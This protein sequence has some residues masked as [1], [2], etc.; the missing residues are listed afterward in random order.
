[1]ANDIQNFN[2]RVIYAGLARM[3]ADRSVIKSAFAYWHKNFQADRLNIVDVVTEL[4]AYLGL[5]SLEKKTLMVA[6][7]AASN[8]LFDE[9]TPVPGVILSADA[10]STVSDP[11][12]DADAERSKI[13]VRTPHN[14]VTTFYLKLFAQNIRK[15]DPSEFANFRNLIS[16]SGLDDLNENLNKEVRKWASSGLA[17]IELPAQTSEEDCIQI[18]H[19]LYI[20]ATE[21]VGPMEA[22]DA[23]HN[24][25]QA[26][27]NLIRENLCDPRKSK[28]II[29]FNR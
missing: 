18:A 28:L 12:Q 4:V 10:Q 2:N 6:L 21:F 9:L 25:I 17:D 1:M 23:V 5:S 24:A 16:A 29:Q 11:D 15:L 13:I 8:K 7:H 3:T 14:E 26:C 27:L 22:D 19:S 20:L